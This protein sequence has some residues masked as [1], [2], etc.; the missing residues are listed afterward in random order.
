MTDI[1]LIGVFASSI[2]T[3]LVT[4]AIKQMLD[5][6]QRLNLLAGVV[7]VVVSAVLGFGYVLFIGESFT[8]QMLIYILVLIVMSWLC[9]MLGY[10][11]VIQ[12]ISQITEVGD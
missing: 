5:K 9:A 12:T 7:S 10:D 11:K 2:L 3:G 8:I 4:E 6:T 1:L